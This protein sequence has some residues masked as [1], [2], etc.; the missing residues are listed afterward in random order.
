MTLKTIKG[1]NENSWA[2]FKSLA[3][4]NKIKMGLLFERML[5]DYKKKSEESW[6]LI[7]SGKKILSDKE[8]ENMKKTIE[9]SRREYGFRI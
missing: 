1:I 3:A 5:E 7:L 2:E 4:K 8:A 6:N 9:E